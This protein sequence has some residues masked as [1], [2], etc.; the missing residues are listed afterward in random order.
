MC[1][2]LFWCGVDELVVVVVYEFVV[3]GLLS[4]LGDWVCVEVCCFEWYVQWCIEGEYC[5]L[6]WCDVDVFQCISQW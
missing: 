5:C 2:V 6:V 4:D 3:V 1:G